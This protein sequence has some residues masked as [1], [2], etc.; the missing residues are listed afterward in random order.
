MRA[1]PTSNEAKR[2]MKLSAQNAPA[3]A[4]AQRMRSAPIVPRSFQSAE[5]GTEN[6]AP[7]PRTQTAAA[8]KGVPCSA[9]PCG[10][11]VFCHSSISPEPVPLTVKLRGRTEAP[12]GAEGAQFLGARGAKPQARHGPLQRLLDVTAQEPLLR[13]PSPDRAQ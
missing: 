3:E 8:T 1:T 7:K 9:K 12:H 5:G 4:A 6:P 10:A 2:S 11:V 13:L